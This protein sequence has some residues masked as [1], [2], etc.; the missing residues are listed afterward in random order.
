MYP[1]LSVSE[2][3]PVE[4]QLEIFYE[5]STSGNFVDLNRQ[6]VADYAG[7]SG[8]T[9][10]SGNFDESEPLSSTVITSF[11]FTDSATNELTLNNTPLITQ[12]LDAN[13]VDV[14][15]IFTIEPTVAFAY[16]DFDIKTTTDFAYLK[17][18]GSHANQWS[19]TFQT[20]YTTPGLETFIDTLSNQITINLNNVAPTIGGFTPTQTSDADN[21]VE[22]AC[23]KPGGTPGYDTTMTG[24]IGQFTNVVNGS[25][26][27]AQQSLELCYSLAIISEPLG[28]TSVFS[29]DQSG[30]VS[31]TTGTI[32]GSYIFECIVTDA[33]PACS[34]DPNSLTF[35]CQYEI[36]FG[37]PPVNQALCF[38][39]T[40]QMG[41]LDTTCTNN[42]GEPLEVF[43]GAN[44]FVNSGIIGNVG[45]VYIGS[46]TNEETVN[47][48][49][50]LG[51]LGPSYGLSSNN[52]ID[53]AYYN[54]LEEGRY[55]TNKHTCIETNPSPP[56]AFITTTPAFTTGGLT[57][58]ILAIQ[59]VLSKTP[60]SGGFDAYNTEYTILYRATAVDTWQIATADALSPTNPGSAVGGFNSLAV[61]LSG[62]VQSEQTYYFSAPGEYAV[63]TNGVHNG[64]GC[65]VS[66]C[67]TCARVDVNFYDALYGPAAVACT[68]CDGPL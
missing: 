40:S 13:G 30:N 56:P 67:Y 34:N 66:G 25:V 1:Y 9:V 10:T 2:T 54:V 38:G 68:D 61:N 45:I 65:Q 27:V 32:N 53:L 28:S 52:G 4:S 19:L 58:G 14:T 63:R 42:T 3:Q 39:P 16:D 20:N 37:T 51:A 31:I 46:D 26:A 55:A 47:I 50:G 43:F 5:S 35:Q 44:R 17:S 60:T 7:V 8:T 64:N 23:S 59:V 49:A 6:V 62:A 41:L 33:S 29:I 15:G 11:S 21:G 48:D 12:V 36:V 22:Q 24:V 57:Q 18:S